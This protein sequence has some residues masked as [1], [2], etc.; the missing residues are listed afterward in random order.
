MAC[1]HYRFPFQ[2][3]YK[4]IPLNGLQIT[5]RDMKAQI[6]K[7]EHLKSSNCDLKISNDQDEGWLITRECT[8]AED[9][10]EGLV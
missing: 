5:V 6:M 4:F 10:H 7:Q 2:A 9:H 3:D 1:I 8:E